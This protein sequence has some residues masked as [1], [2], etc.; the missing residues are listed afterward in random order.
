MIRDQT[1]IKEG[2]KIKG[3]TNT[4]YFKNKKIIWIK[5]NKYIF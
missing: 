5:K 2:K 3:R 4:K 1:R